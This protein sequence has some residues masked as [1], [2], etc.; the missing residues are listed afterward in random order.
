MQSM[1]T[2]T[3]SVSGQ[4]NHPG[5]WVD[6]LATAPDGH[7]LQSWAWGELKTRFGWQ[8]VRLAVGSAGAQ[9]LLRHLPLG[10]GSIAYVPRGPVA[11]FHDEAAL[12]ALLNKIRRLARSARAICLKIE[13]NQEDDPEL[14]R[15]LHDLGFRPSPQGVQPRRTIVVDLDAGPEEILAR[16]KQKTRYN[17]RLAGRRGVTVR[18]GTEDD[19]PAFYDLMAATGQRDGFDIHSRA[20]YETAHRLLVSAGHGRLLLAEYDGNLLAALV[21]VAFGDGAIYL[22]GASSE[23]ERQ[24]MPA[25]LLQWEAMLWAREHGCRTYD[26]WGVPDED[27]ATL[28]ASFTE[29]ND[30]LWG[31]YRFKR[32]FGGRLVRTIGA[33]D[34]VYA[35]LR[36]RLYTAAVEW[37][38]RREAG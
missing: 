35:P 18:P 28:E 7:L 4:I 16:M 13:P 31:V 34:L 5:V 15:R 2:S 38:N 33:W 6:W 10:L 37:L 3:A 23:E 11:D 27:E 29:R 17:V 26:L 1:S 22:Y 12:A 20:Y 25:Y 8:V 24:R 30:G 9:V 32:G 21:V 36:Y 19:L 14:Y